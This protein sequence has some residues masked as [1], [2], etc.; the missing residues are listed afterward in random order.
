LVARQFEAV[1]LGGAHRLAHLAQGV[2]G[3]GGV[4]GMATCFIGFHD[5]APFLQV[6]GKAAA[7]GLRHARDGAFAKHYQPGAGGAAP[8]FLW[9]ADQYIDTDR[10]HVYPQ[11]AGGDAVEHE[12]AADLAH[13]CADGLQV[14]IR[15]DDAGG[16]FH[17]RR[18]NHGRALRTY[19]G[20]HL[21]QRCRRPGCLRVLG[22]APGL[23]HAGIR[24]VIRPMSRICDQR[25]LNQPLRR[26]RQRASPANWRATA[27]MA[28]V[29]PPG[30]TATASA[31]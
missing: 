10:A 14:V 8:A 25:K 3:Q 23:E 26:I 11:R 4:V 30:T 18:E 13:R 24:E 16:G 12:Q 27:S 22:R 19:R 1:C 15:Q 6:A 20:E 31:P 29:P 5:L 28:K 9:R 2:G 17:V 21:G 7:G